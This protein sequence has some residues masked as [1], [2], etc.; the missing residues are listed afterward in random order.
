MVKSGRVAV[1]GGSVGGLTAALLLRD[2]GLDVTVYERSGA[3]LEQRGAGIGFLPDS[4][5]YLVERAHVRLDDISVIVDQVRHLDRH[6]NVAHAEERRYHFSNWNTVYRSLLSCF[7][8]KR[9]LLGHE[10]IDITQN[11]DQ[12]RVKFASGEQVEVDLVVCADGVGST[13]RSRLLPETTPRYA[14]YVAWRGL[15]PERNLRDG[16][17]ALIDAITHYVYANSHILAYPIPGLDGSVAAG[18]RLINFVW[19]RNYLAGSDLDDLMTDRDGLRHDI[20]LPPGTARPE[21]VHELHATAAARLP[22]RMAEI[23]LAVER[24]FV[25]AILDVEVP[26]MAF[27]RVCLVGDAAFGVRPHAAAGT[28]KAAFDAWELARALQEQPDIESALRA[29]EPGQLEVGRNLLQRTRRMGNRS[30]FDGNWIPG[31]PE[32]IFGL[33]EP[34]R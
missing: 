6:D 25:Q 3:E 21:H 28:A 12:V 29:W 7:G 31:D 11:G 33:H 23:V 18:E 32:L 13:N 15:V 22:E 34:G 24:P 1:I 20:S 10:S 27:G 30:Q 26:R 16:G 8:R 9:Y 19:Y 5:R 17:A 4:Y 14:G 2:L